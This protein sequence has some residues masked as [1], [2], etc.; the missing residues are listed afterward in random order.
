PPKRLLPFADLHSG[1]LIFPAAQALAPFLNRPALCPGCQLSANFLPGRPTTRAEAAVVL[2]S[3]LVAADKLKLLDAASSNGVLANVSDA[4][5]VPLAA[6]PFLATALQAGNLT[7][8][9]G[10]TLKPNQ[11]YTHAELTGA[12]NTIQTHFGTLAVPAL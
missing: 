5:G 11:P 9:A 7:L 3:V 1:D 12:L 8:D 10:N 2:V 6:R 4:G